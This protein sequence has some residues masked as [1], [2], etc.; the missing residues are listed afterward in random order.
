MVG[1]LNHWDANQVHKNELLNM[2]ERV[3]N[4]LEFDFEWTTPLH[5]VPRF[6]R[7]FGIDRVNEDKQSLL[8][9]ASTFYLC[10]FMMR[11]TAFLDF[12]PS[13]IGAA[14]FIMAMN[15]SLHK[16]LAKMPDTSHHKHFG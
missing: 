11:D 13:H 10:R 15:A 7:L 4:T 3:L 9:Q 12:K 2:E 16:P 5:F 1:L 6:E 14:A 8:I